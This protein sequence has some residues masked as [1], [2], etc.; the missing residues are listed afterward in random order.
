MMDLFGNMNGV[1]KPLEVEHWYKCADCG[2]RFFCS[3]SLFRE[4][5]QVWKFLRG[6]GQALVERC[7][8]ALGG[9]NVLCGVR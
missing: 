5:P 1:I 4:M 7:C 6:R 2:K 3:S 8:G 9:L